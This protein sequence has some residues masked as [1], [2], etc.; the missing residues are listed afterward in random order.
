MAIRFRLLGPWRRTLT[1]SRWILVMRGSGVC[2]SRCWWL[3]AGW[4]RS[5][6]CST[7]CGA[8]AI[9]VDHRRRENLLEVAVPGSEQRRPSPRRPLQRSTRRSDATRFFSP[10]SSLAPASAAAGSVLTFSH[11]TP[12]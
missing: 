10:S 4:C 6:C 2:W 11:R 3:P 9:R 5:M 8:T 1:A 7:G 12:R